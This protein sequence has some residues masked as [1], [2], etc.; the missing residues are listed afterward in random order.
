MLRNTII[1]TLSI[2]LIA[3]PLC[4]GLA[5]CVDE[6]EFDDTPQGNFEA[7]WRII[8]EHYCFF[9]YKKQQY[10]LDWNEVHNRYQKQF[11]PGMTQLQM[12]E[13]LANMLSE[14]RD[15]H[16]NIYTPFDVARNWAWHEDYPSNF[17]D[18]I[19][20]IYLRTDYRIASGIRYRVLDDNIG[21]LRYSSFSSAI[22][23]GNLDE[24]LTYLAPCHAL[25]IDIRNNSGGLLTYAEQLAARF[26]NEEI[27]VGYMQ[28]KTGPGHNDFSSME[29]QKLKPSN[30]VRWQKPVAV[31]TNRSVYSAAN[32]FVK[33]MKQCPKATIIGDQTGGGAGMPFSSELPCGW[34]IRFSACP[35]YDVH[36]Q[37]T[38]FGIQ[39]DHQVSL[40]DEDFARGRDTI[41]EYARKLLTKK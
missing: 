35:M 6:D 7:L 41:I 21:Y 11:A 9:D 25:I 24:V 40:T 5:S 30:G 28:H 10:G 19:L 36:Q 12:F 20:N 3:C 17:S 29:E 34:S 2:F 4:A 16:V 26:T 37:S 27:L 23:E 31:L 18:T 14:L 13:V 15:G 1:K 33:Y 39:P 32:E 38:E 22:G 8:D